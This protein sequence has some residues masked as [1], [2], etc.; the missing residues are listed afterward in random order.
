MIFAVMLS[1]AMYSPAVYRGSFAGK[2]ARNRER[3][4]SPPLAASASETRR[5]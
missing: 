4:D 3:R 2:G 5:D 1:V